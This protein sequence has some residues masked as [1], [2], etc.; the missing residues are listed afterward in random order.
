MP[1]ASC[2]ACTAPSDLGLE[3]PAWLATGMTGKKN[4][5]HVGKRR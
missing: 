4:A 5:C 3:S 2:S 1:V